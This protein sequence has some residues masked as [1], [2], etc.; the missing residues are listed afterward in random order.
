MTGSY[1][2]PRVQVIPQ[3]GRASLCIDGVER[4][5]YEFGEG[6]S[7]P[8]LFPLVGPSGATLTRLGHPNP[9]GHEHHKSIWFGHGNVG[10][11]NFWEERPNT[12]IRIR[13]QSVRL[14]QDGYDWAGLVAEL[15]WWAHGRSILRQEL[16]IVIEPCP[17]NG[18][19]LDVQSLFESS[20]GS[21]VELG[22]T[23]FGFL[24]IRVAKTMSEQFG[25]GRLT[26]ANGSHGEKAIFGKSSRW[27]D[28]SGPSAP[29]KVEGI[30]V[31]DHPSNCNHPTHWH[32]R[33]DGW[34]GASFNRESSHG[35]ARDHSLS[36]RHRLLVHSGTADADVLSSAWELYARTPAYLIDSS[37]ELELAAL[38]R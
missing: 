29:G 28:Y 30:C 38:T 33:G 18:Y 9:V 22:R 24:G 32:V 3:I 37:K 35:V 17:Y 1:A 16:T 19:A 10:G 5:G 12:D 27:V 11:I 15:D 4:V 25:G 2:F 36:V 34:I 14:Y 6:A 7:R 26:D 23:N 21:P 20:D 8:F 13:H 31:M